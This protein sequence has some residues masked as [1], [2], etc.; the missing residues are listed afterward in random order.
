MRSSFDFDYFDYLK[1]P[2]IIPVY[3]SG[4]SIIPLES[5][6]MLICSVF[7]PFLFVPAIH[8]TYI[9]CTLDGTRYASVC[10]MKQAATK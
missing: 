4:F 1:C 2:I 5:L 10:G 6:F 8:I 3:I 7:T 9:S